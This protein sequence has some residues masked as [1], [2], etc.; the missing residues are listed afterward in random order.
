MRAAHERDRS[1][2]PGGTVELVELGRVDAARSDGRLRVTLYGDDPAN[3]IAADEVTLVGDAG[4]IPFRVRE[5]TGAGAT[6]DG[7]ARVEL[8]LSGLA[9]RDAALRWVGSRV[10]IPESALAP[11]PEGEF[12]WRELIGT[13]CRTREGRVLGTVEEIWP[14]A[15]HD[16]LVVREGTGEWLVPATDA[17]LVQLDREAGELVVDPPPGLFDPPVGDA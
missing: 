4:S 7:R 6:R 3:L 16:L 10:A 9:D 12:Y 13:R 15:A 17:V 8:V 5:A 1:N 2:P 14:T 11:L